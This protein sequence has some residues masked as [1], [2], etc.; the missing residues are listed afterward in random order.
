[1]LVTT[2]MAAA[3]AAM[4]AGCPTQKQL[5]RMPG[6]GD[7]TPLG[8]AGKKCYDFCAQSKVQCD[9]MCPHGGDI[10]P[11]DCITESKVCLED[12]PDLQRPVYPED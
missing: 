6:L 12:C 10:C 3:I 4:T 5:A 11:D 7:V 2:L 8:P 9:T 1:M